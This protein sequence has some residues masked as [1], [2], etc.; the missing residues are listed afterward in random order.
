MEASLSASHE[1]KLPYPDSP[2]VP[3][4]P[5]V[6]GYVRSLSLAPGDMQEVM[7]AGNGEPIRPSLVRIRGPQDDFGA[8]S[9][10]YSLEDV[11]RPLM[12]P[13][14]P[15]PQ[16]VPL[17]S[18]AIVDTLDIDVPKAGFK[19]SVRFF[20]TRPR[21]GVPQTLIMYR[22]RD[23]NAGFHLT[24]TEEGEC[25]AGWRDLGSAYG[26]R[27]A[28]ALIP[29]VW[30]EASLTFHLAEAR[31]RLEL[32]SRGE[33][34]F[35]AD[36]DQTFARE[37]WSALDGSLALGGP[38]A[39]TDTL[40]G[41]DGKL[42]APRFLELRSS[43]LTEHEAPRTLAGWD[44]GA[45]PSSSRLR[46]IGPASPTGRWVNLPVRPAAGWSWRG[47]EVDPRLDP[48]GL[49]AAHLHTDDLSDCAWDPTFRF[50]VPPN[51]PSGVYGVELN[52]PSGRGDIVPFFV[53]RNRDRPPAKVLFIAPTLSYLAYAND[54]QFM[55][56]HMADLRARQHDLCARDEDLAHLDGQL[57]RSLYDVHRDGSGIAFSSHWRPM[58]NMRPDYV[59][60]LTGSPRHFSADLSII[61]WLDGTGYLYDVVTDH[62][63]H[64]EGKELLERYQ[65]VVT[66]NHPEYYTLDMLDA[67]DEYLEDGGKLMY[68]GGNGF[69][70]VTNIAGEHNEAIEVRRGYAGSRTWESHPAEIHS[71]ATGE[72]GGLWRHRGRAPSDLV[73]VEFTAQGWGQGSGYRVL[74]DFPEDLRWILPEGLIPGMT[75]GRYGWMGGSAGDEVDRRPSQP[76]RNRWRSVVRIASSEPLGP[77]Y[78]PVVEDHFDVRPDVSGS[79]QNPDIRSDVVL[80]TRYSGGT[81]FSTGSL[82]WAGG[83]PH[84]RFN[85]YV[86]SL[87]ENILS[88]FIEGAL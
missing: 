70:W 68:L 86:A 41:F 66:G 28:G 63:L 88:A 25:F 44:L 4:W 20:P 58:L 75:F 38:L 80:A 42:D 82:N 51:L 8:A 84:R 67:I 77:T 74:E 6:V 48:V 3:T 17:G 36:V 64:D 12:E 54:T 23:G 29:K 2:P 87:T 81:V 52:P 13:A 32:T 15:G 31:V 39:T 79:A 26:V 14:A 71:G 22:S 16:A 27:M 85:N 33:G 35:S 61:S 5:G 56:A 24:L 47:Q 78:H 53:R 69:Y 83:L 30:Y 72:L 73:G 62:D 46:G 76:D 65:V 9:D 55:G 11:S 40:G 19:V 1:S 45:D 43:V 60:W 10:W 49:S 57:G 21:T 37:S 18:Y 59:S 34:P 7:V 50:V